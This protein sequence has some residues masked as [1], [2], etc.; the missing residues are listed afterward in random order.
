MRKRKIREARRNLLGTGDTVVN[1][2]V[3]VRI[4]PAATNDYLDI[5]ARSHTIAK[6]KIHSRKSNAD[7]DPHTIREVSCATDS[8]SH[9][10]G[11]DL[12]TTF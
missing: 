4:L 6:G 10:L 8:S 9:A 11:L 2:S 1:L 7:H 12:V 3:R 5:Q